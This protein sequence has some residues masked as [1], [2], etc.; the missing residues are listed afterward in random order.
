M[1]IRKDIRQQ[2]LALLFNR[3]SPG[4]QVILEELFIILLESKS[5]RR[6]ILRLNTRLS[7]GVKVLVSKIYNRKSITKVHGFSLVAYRAGYPWFQNQL[8]TFAAL[9]ISRRQQSESLI[10]RRVVNVLEH[11]AGLSA[12]SHRN[13]YWSRTDH[14]VHDTNIRRGS[15]SICYL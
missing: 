11:S 6:I 14:L 7:L 8:A 2:S 4:R 15:P 1:C 3:Q 5:P 13:S 9:T 12:D 10:T